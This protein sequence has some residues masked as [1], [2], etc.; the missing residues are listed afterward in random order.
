MS[1]TTTK[2]VKFVGTQKFINAATGE[3]QEMQ[4]TDIEE[5]DFN[6]TKV[7]VA[8]IIQT[9]DLI[10]G[11][12]IKVCTYIIDNASKD[13]VF[14]GSQRE[15]ADRTHVSLK[16]VNVTIKALLDADFIRMRAPGAYILNPDMLFRGSRAGR[17]N[18]LQQYQNAD[19]IPLTDEE[20]L[21][22]LLASI[23]ELQQ[24]AIQLQKKITIKN[25]KA[26]SEPES[27]PA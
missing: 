19:Y 23:N 8:N 13:N 2:K 16:T 20:K 1:N 22:N 21:K 17:L 5:R 10:G 26:E 15:I 9:L 11:Q 14:W 4:V 7:W 6:F 18:V 12:K 3:I 25:Q 27:L 24:K